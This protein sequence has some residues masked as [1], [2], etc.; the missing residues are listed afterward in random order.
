MVGKR[1]DNFQAS[2]YH[3]RLVG[4]GIRHHGA[5]LAGHQNFAAVSNAAVRLLPEK[6]E[7]H[8]LELAVD[9]LG[10]KSHFGF[11]ENLTQVNALFGLLVLGGQALF[12]GFKFCNALALAFCGRCL[13]LHIA[14]LAA[15][16]HSRLLA[17]VHFTKGRALLLLGR[18]DLAGNGLDGLC[19]DLAALGFG[20]VRAGRLCLDGLFAGSVN[21]IGAGRGSFRLFIEGRNI[22]FKL[23]NGFLASL[24]LALGVDGF[25]FGGPALEEVCAEL[26][27]LFL[28]QGLAAGRADLAVLV[29]GFGRCL[30]VLGQDFGPAGLHV[31]QVCF[32]PPGVCGGVGGFRLGLQK[33]GFCLFLGLAVLGPG[34][35]AFLNVRGFCCRIVRLGVCQEAA[36]L[37][38]VTGQNRPFLLRNLGFLC[39]CC[40]QLVRQVFGRREVLVN[41]AGCLVNAVRDGFDFLVQVGF[42][43]GRDLPVLVH[44]I[45]AGRAAGHFQELGQP[46]QL[47]GAGDHVGVGN[48]AANVQQDFPALRP[49][50]NGGKIVGHGQQLHGFLAA[51]IL[52]DGRRVLLFLAGDAVDLVVNGIPGVFLVRAA[53]LA[54]PNFVKGLFQ[55]HGL[56]VVQLEGAGCAVFQVVQVPVG[57]LG[58][59]V[60]VLRPCAG[61]AEKQPGDG[62]ENGGLAAGVPAVNA[63]AVAVQLDFLMLQALEVFKA[64]RQKFHCVSS[65]IFRKNRDKLLVCV[66]G[67]SIF[68]GPSLY[69]PG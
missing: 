25:Q 16:V 55:D 44:L 67:S 19:N 64:Q 38:S 51:A 57:A 13:A 59:G 4:G 11:Y 37:G 58:L 52:L 35:A 7:T 69:C 2:V 49:V 26:F 6:L 45:K 42:L 65:L 43:G 8:G 60:P 5:A 1:G 32:L 24:F 30:F 29:P 53:T 62:V 66:L 34:L 46:C 31:F 48:V 33:L 54:L 18:L 68:G 47:R 21:F 63:G 12:L 10:Q 3:G 9:P 17:L 20:K 39:L 15:V 22:L 41:G 28:R 14:D 36:E 27:H 23:G 56:A 50:H 61:F 40:G